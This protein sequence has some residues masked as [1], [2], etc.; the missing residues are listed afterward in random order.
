VNRLEDCW[1]PE[2]MHNFQIPGRRSPGIVWWTQ[3]KLYLLTNPSFWL[4]K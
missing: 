2:N 4:A 1:D 3:S